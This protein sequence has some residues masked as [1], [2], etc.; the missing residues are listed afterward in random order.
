[1]S[2]RAAARSVIL[3]LAVLV[4]LSEGQ[5]ATVAEHPGSAALARYKREGTLQETLLAFRRRY[6]A[7]LAEQPA[8]RQAATYRPMVRHVPAPIGPGGKTDSARGRAPQCPVARRPALMDAQERVDRRPDRDASSEIRQHVHLPRGTIRAKRPVRL[9][10]G[11]GGGDRLEVWLNGRKAA[12]AETHLVSGRYGCSDVRRRHAGRPGAGGSGSAGGGERARGP[13]DARRRAVVLLLG[14]AASRCRGSGN[15]CAAISRGR[16]PAVGPRARRLVRDARA[17]SRPR[18]T[19]FEEQLI[20]RLAA[21]C[22][23]DAARRSGRNSTGCSRRKADRDDR[24][25]ARPVRQGV[26]ARPRST[27]IWPGSAPR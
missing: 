11:I 19:Q 3:L 23:G 17:G 4:P 10:V 26:G 20:D 7:W 14:R 9:T 21:D 18:D 2:K 27:A 8:A 5:A 22:G 24:A 1:M 25:L 6:S 15:R 12:C 16:E 13:A